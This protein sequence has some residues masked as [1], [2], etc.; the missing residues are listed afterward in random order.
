VLQLPPLSGWRVLTH[1]DAVASWQDFGITDVVATYRLSA[2]VSARAQEEVRSATHFYWTSSLQF[3]AVR[4][5]LPDAAHH[6]CG[7]GKTI[8]AL[9]QAG[10]PD[11]QVFPSVKEWRAWLA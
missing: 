11:L 10:V 2:E 4:D 8:R 5:W 9:T 6:A 3:L 7:P 1:A